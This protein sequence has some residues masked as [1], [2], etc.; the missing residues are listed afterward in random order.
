ML[1]LQGRATAA[2]GWQEVNQAPTGPQ[3][4]RLF[5]HAESGQSDSGVH[6]CKFPIGP[7][8]LFTVRLSR[9]I[10]LPKSVWWVA[11]HSIEWLPAICS[12]GPGCDLEVANVTCHQS[13]KGSCQAVLREV[14]SHRILLHGGV[15]VH[16]H[17]GSCPLHSRCEEEASAAAERVTDPAPRHYPG[18]VRHDEGGLVVHGAGGEIAPLAEPVWVDVEAWGELEGHHHFTTAIPC[19]SIW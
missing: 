16:S 17:N 15:D 14:L 10:H 5:R 11:D 7:C 8:Q 18:N 3:E 13:R 19:V 4:G 2:V 6:G 9:G 12:N 1:T